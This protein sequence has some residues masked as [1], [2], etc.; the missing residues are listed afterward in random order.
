MVFIWGTLTTNHEPT[1]V[2]FIL[3]E[4]CGLTNAFFGLERFGL[5]RKIDLLKLIIKTKFWK[6]SYISLIST[7]WH[8][9]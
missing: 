1:A 7:D 2:L 4:G 9:W 3:L 8:Y 5:I 6:I